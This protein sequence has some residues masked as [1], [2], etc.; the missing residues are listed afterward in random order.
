MFLDKTFSRPKVLLGPKVFRPENLMYP[1][2]KIQ[3]KNSFWTHNSFQTLYPDLK[4]ILPHNFFFENFFRI[5]QT[6]IFLEAKIYRPEILL[7]P[8]TFSTQNFYGFSDQNSFSRPNFFFGT[9]Y[10]RTQN[11]F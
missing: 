6:Q 11:F 5:F 2:K 8:V 7:V 9:K 3:I 4:L 1:K 10:F